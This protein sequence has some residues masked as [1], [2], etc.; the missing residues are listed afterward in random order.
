MNRRAPIALLVFVIALTVYLITLAPAV[1]LIDSGELTDAAWSLGNAHPPG[2]P[3]FVLVTHFFT[4][5]PI[6]TIAWR[7]N[8]ASAIFSAL[9][10]A[11]TA[12]AAWEVVIRVTPLPP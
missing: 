4:L 2:F 9:A 5:V 6:G 8:L 12:L 10:A 3:L 7:A 1:A 11:F